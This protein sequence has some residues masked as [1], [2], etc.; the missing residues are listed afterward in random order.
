MTGSRIR[1]ARVGA[2]A[3]VLAVPA[4]AFGAQSSASASPLPGGLL[5]Q[6]FTN[7]LL[8]GLAS[9]TDLGAADPAS[10]M[11]LVVGLSRPNPAGESA[12]LAGENDP[13]SP[14]YHQFLTPS[15]FAAKFGVPASTR[16]AVTSWLTG[17][18]LHVDSVSAAGDNYAVSGTVS[19]VDSA[20]RTSIR[21]FTFGAKNFLANT[22]FPQVP[23][24]LPVSTIV[25]LNTLQ[26]FSTPAK[27]T[28]A[29]DTCIGSTCLGVTT[30]KDLWSVYDQPAAY[31]GQGQQLAV[32][33]EGQ[34]RR[35][36]LRPAPVRDR[37][38]PAAD[39]RHRQAPRRRHRLHRRL[40]PRRVEH[41]HPGLVRHGAA[42]LRDDA[43][44]RLRSVRRRRA[45]DVP[46]VDRRRERPDAG[47]RLVRRTRDQPDQP[48]HRRSAVDP[49][50]S[51]HGGPRQQPAAAGGGRPQAG[52]ARG[53]DAVQLD[54]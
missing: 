29:Q 44:L 33:G 38:W 13:Q 31:Q 46:A 21:R 8:P 37:Q 17:A 47:E 14:L 5:P 3:A 27:Q 12:Y 53:Q 10:H 4:L 11:A 48:G 30:P 1:R 54:G 23:S 41:R 16:S 7:N 35:R 40:G 25:G 43:L 51:G 15:T 20:F 19:Q 42:G 34:K 2:A 52:G 28:P 49:P 26:G 39:P 24:G 36:H 50:A 18:G 45:E 32:F 6:L 22:S 9:A